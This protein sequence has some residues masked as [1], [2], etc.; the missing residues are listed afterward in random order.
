MGPGDE[1]HGIIVKML[2]RYRTLKV[3]TLAM[4]LG[5]AACGSDDDM[6]GQEDGGGGDSGGINYPVE[7]LFDDTLVHDIDVTVDPAEWDAINADPGAE[8][9]I[10]ATM[11]IE[12]HVQEGA[13]I[14]FKGGFNTLTTC[15]LNP[16]SCLKLSFKLKFNNDANPKDRF[17]GLRKFNL[18]SAIRDPSMTR[19]VLAYSAYRA[20]GIEAPRAS[21]ARLTVNGEYM[22]LFVLVEAVDKEFVED[23][24][25]PGEGNLYKEAWPRFDETIYPGFLRTNESESDVSRMVEFETMLDNTSDA[26]FEADIAPFMD[27]DK[28]GRYL[29]VDRALN[30]LDGVSIFYCDPPNAEGNVICF[31]H[32]NYLYEKDNGQFELTP[33]DMDR[34]MGGVNTDLGIE[35]NGNDCSLIPQC[36]FFGDAPGCGSPTDP[37]VL[38]SQCDPLFG[39]LHRATYN[40]SYRQGL[41]DLLDGRFDDL[42]EKRVAIKSKLEGLIPDDPHHEGL[43]KFE[44]F[45][46][47]LRIVLEETPAAMQNRVDSI[48]EP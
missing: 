10:A 9:Y 3:L 42:A 44:E 40:T 34:V 15:L 6:P 8:E 36:E 46:T 33:W 48:P 29:A 38:P 37:T 5:A 39:H 21:H 4:C 17:A 7:R 22:G 25:A 32:N 2:N 43:A 13:A 30:N 24:F 41:V 26:T 1:I 35:F 11:N 16:G 20:M 18:H 14:R 45:H 31:N 27:L 47:S 23:H 19:D 12:D 28:V